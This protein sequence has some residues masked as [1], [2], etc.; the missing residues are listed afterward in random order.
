MAGVSSD[1]VVAAAA[2][3][4]TSFSY[5]L[6]YMS[7]AE[8]TTFSTS[9]IAAISN[10]TP[11]LSSLP[12]HTTSASATA[13]QATG[14]GPHHAA[15]AVP[16]SIGTAAVLCIV[17]LL[18]RKYHPQSFR[19]ILDSIPFFG[20]LGRW[21]KTREKNNQ[22]RRMRSLGVLTGDNNGYGGSGVGT[23][24]TYARHLKKFED[25]AA[26]AR[27][28]ILFETPTRTP[29]TPFTP[30]PKLSRSGEGTPLSKLGSPWRSPKGKQLSAG[31]QEPI[32]W[33]STPTKSSGRRDYGPFKRNGNNDTESLASWEEKW[34]AMG[35]KGT[36]SIA[37]AEP[38]ATEAVAE[39]HGMQQT[40]EAEDSGPGQSWRKLV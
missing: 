16:M 34:L 15:I 35:A 30:D 29:V 18:W 13:A 1:T 5:T 36:P 28:K 9:T 3:S 12:T 7:A 38:P 24:D 32:L 40:V 39:G 25:D 11:S 31:S 23:T 26:R 27:G 20:C 17:V 8:S 21:R 10:T 2:T 37:T 14:H 33:D 4:T 22:V 19:K 6:G